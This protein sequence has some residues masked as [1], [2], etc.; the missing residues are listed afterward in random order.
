MLQQFLNLVLATLACEKLIAEKVHFLY[1]SNVAYIRVH[2]TISN[3]LIEN[4][5]I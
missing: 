4:P 3:I 1:K 5:Q 2:D